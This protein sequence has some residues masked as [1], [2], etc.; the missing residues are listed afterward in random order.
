MRAEVIT[1]LE[2]PRRGFLR[3][4][5]GGR[6]FRVLAGAARGLWRGFGNRRGIEQQVSVLDALIAVGEGAVLHAG[7]V[8]EAR[9]RRAEV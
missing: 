4:W 6:G 2:G 7:V 8:A 5:Y 1:G 3:G 9:G